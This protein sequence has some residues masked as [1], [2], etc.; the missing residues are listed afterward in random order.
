VPLLCKT[1]PLVPGAT[2]RKLVVPFPRITLLA[3][4]EANPVPPFAT[5]SVPVTD[6]VSETFVTVLEAPL[7]VLFDSVAV[8]VA[9]STFD[10][11]MMSERLAMTYSG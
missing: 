9:V 5:G 8:L 11:V 10:G 2:V 4:T 7:I 6:A 1:L 3:V